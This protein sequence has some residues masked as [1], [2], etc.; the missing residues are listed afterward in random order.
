M[1]YHRTFCIQKVTPV[2][3]K[4]IFLEQN[5]TLTELFKELNGTYILLNDSI[6]AVLIFSFL[7]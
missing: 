6:I 5:G 2:P 3:E 7:F 1:D 4:N